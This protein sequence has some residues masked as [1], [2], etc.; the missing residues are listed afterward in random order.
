M[1]VMAGVSAPTARAVRIADRA[2]ITL[3]GLARADSMLAF[4]HIERLVN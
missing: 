3:V 4:T 1:P 2:G